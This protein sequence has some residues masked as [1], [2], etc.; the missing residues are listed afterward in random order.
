MTYLSV[1][2]K[3][4]LRDIASHVEPKRASFGGAP[5]R[6]FT[7]DDVAIF[8]KI[9]KATVYK[10][11]RQEKIPAH[12]VGKHWRFLREEVEAWLRGL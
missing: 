5:D 7:I 3:D 8:L 6:I 4:V 9:P 12:K 1:P 11:V 2:S 10:L